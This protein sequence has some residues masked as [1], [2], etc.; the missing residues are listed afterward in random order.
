MFDHYN[1]PITGVIMNDDGSV[2][3]TESLTRMAT[4]EFPDGNVEVELSARLDGIIETEKGTCVLEIKGVGFNS[5]KWLNEAWR[6]GGE[7]AV[8]E[9]VKDKHRYW[10]S[11]CQISM[12]I[13]Q[14]KYPEI[15]NAYLVVKDR[16]SGALG[17]FD[18]K[19]GHGTIHIPY[20]PDEVKAVTQRMGVVKK[21]LDTGVPPTRR[22]EGS[23]DC[24]WCNFHYLCYGADTRRKKNLE[25]V[26]LYPGP[27]ID[28]HV[29]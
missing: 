10:Y 15:Q 13:I 7:E 24:T 4:A 1:I 2:E 28:H 8:F 16:S 22:I 14:Q 12:F 3:E 17:F 5:F 9:R 11:Q 6:K 26:I 23:M 27:Q 21:A 19:R 29:E 20:D 18:E 25:P